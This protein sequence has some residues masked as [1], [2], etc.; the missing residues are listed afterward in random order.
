M[1]PCSD[2]TV[3]DSPRALSAGSSGRA[4]SKALVRWILYE[5]WLAF[6]SFSHRSPGYSRDGTTSP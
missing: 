4:V 5:L 1:T 2:G 3:V 6:M